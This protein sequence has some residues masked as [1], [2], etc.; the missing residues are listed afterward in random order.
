LNDV[1]AM[2]G[3]ERLEN[4]SRFRAV[5]QPG[6][7]VGGNGQV[8]RLEVESQLD[9]YGVSGIGASSPAKR[10]VELCAKHTI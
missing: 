6:A 9:L 3:S 8:T 7:E 4:F 1:P 2:R 10:G 5:F